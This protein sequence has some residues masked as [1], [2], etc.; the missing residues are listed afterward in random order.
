MCGW[1]AD[2]LGQLAGTGLRD[3]CSVVIQAATRSS[4]G[5]ARDGR[6]SRQEADV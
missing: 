6:D 1:V 5:A 2:G 4:A 3:L